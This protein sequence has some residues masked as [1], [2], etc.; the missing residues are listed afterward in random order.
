MDPCVLKTTSSKCHVLLTDVQANFPLSDHHRPLVY[1]HI[2]PIDQSQKYGWSFNSVYK[3]TSSK[4]LHFYGPQSN[5]KPDIR[6]S[7]ASYIPT[8]PLNTTNQKMIC[9]VPCKSYTEIN[10]VVVFFRECSWGQW[11]YNWRLMY[12]VTVSEVWVVFCDLIG[13]YAVWYAGLRDNVLLLDRRF[14]RKKE[15]MS[16]WLDELKNRWM[17]QSMYE[18]T[19]ECEK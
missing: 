12:T 3:T 8:T 10:F 7:S 5:Q 19:N 6:P 16:G 4:Y 14:S 15:Y 11:C 17:N 2:V 1:C 13:W 9:M 18:R